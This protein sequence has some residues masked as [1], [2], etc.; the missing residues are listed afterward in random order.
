M[1][2]K[3]SK[4]RLLELMI[5]PAIFVA[6]IALIGSPAFAEVFNWTGPHFGANVGYG[7]A[8]ANDAMTLG[9]I[10]PTDG[11]RD[12]QFLGPLGNQQL[13]PH[14]FTSGIEAGYDYQTGRWVWG[15]EADWEYLGLTDHFTKTIINPFS[16]NPYT[17]ESSFDSDWLVT[18]RPRAGYAF[19]RFLAYA[20]GG[21][22][23]GNQR[24]SQNIIQLNDPYV[25]L[26]YISRT[27]AGWTAGAGG[28]YA[29]DDRWSVKAEYLYVVLGVVSTP[30]N[31]TGG[32]GF[33]LYN[34]THSAELKANIFRVGVNYRL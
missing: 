30:S 14:G 33:A 24:L 17:F 13:H 27:T 19:D 5:R 32:G 16:G 2:H 29:L 31:G 7:F 15:F 3:F 1:W 21:L 22:A 9:G 20:T 8:D 6:M 28:E 25:E 26:A 11:T 23:I 10:W 12:N 18:A 4:M 34:S